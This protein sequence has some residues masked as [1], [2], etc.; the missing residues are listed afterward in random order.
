MSFVD[1]PTDSEYEDRLEYPFHSDPYGSDNDSVYS[2]ELEDLDIDALQDEVSVLFG[3]PC[4]DISKLNEGGFHKIYNLLMMDGSEYIARIALPSYERYKT[5]SEVATMKYIEQHTTIPV[6]KIIHYD[7][8]S[9]NSVGAEYIIMSKVQGVRLCDVWNKMSTAQQKDVLSQ[10]IDIV[11]QLKSLEFPQIG[12]LY[13]NERYKSFEIGEA[14]EMS[15]FLDERAIISDVHRG[16][17]NSTYDYLQSAIQKESIYVKDYGSKSDQQHDLH[18]LDALSRIVT[19]LTQSQSYPSSETFVL[20]HGDLH[21]SN[22]MVHG[23]TITAVIDWECSGAYPLDNLCNYPIWLNDDA[24][25]TSEQSISNNHMR[26]F[27]KAEMESR[28]PEFID[29]IERD[30]SLR[31]KDV[32][33]CLFAAFW[34]RE[35]VHDVV[36]CLL[37]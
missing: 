18:D 9:H 4:I 11:L 19:S 25:T 3:Q 12:S 10:Y 29:I 36:R 8:T 34:D 26:D 7:S 15:W 23:S 20:C 6:P 1:T 37:H 21:S 27:F 32:Y 35:R 22:I 5:E 2:V 24:K 33:H 16:P 28:C 17:F 30:S 31:L 13:Y 14:I